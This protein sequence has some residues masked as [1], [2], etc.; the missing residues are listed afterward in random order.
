MLI[1]NLNDL[2]VRFLFY[3]VG[4]SGL[5]VNRKNLKMNYTDVYICDE[6]DD[7][8]EA[9]DEHSSNIHNYEGKLADVVIIIFLFLTYNKFLILFK[10]IW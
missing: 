2:S 1:K 5:N 7:E 9:D 8:D 6:T 4:E 10:Q 3:V